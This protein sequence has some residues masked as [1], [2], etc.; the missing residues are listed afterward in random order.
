[1]TLK[2][3]TVKDD[4]ESW[5]NVAPI[6]FKAVSA[7]HTNFQ[8]TKKWT[9]KMEATQKKANEAHMELEA[10]VD[11][12]DAALVETRD[13]LET[14]RKEIHS[15][16]EEQGAVLEETRGRVGQLLVNCGTVFKL[17]FEAL[18]T[19]CGET[20]QEGH[21]AVGEAENPVASTTK[22]PD[23]AE[24]RDDAFEASMNSFT[25]AVTRWNAFQSVDFQ[26]RIQWQAEFADMKETTQKTV[27]SMS[28]WQG[29]LAQTIQSVEEMG[30][31]LAGTSNVVEEL[32]A[33]QVRMEDVDEAI[34]ACVRDMQEWIDRAE[35]RVENVAERSNAH[36]AN[37]EQLIGQARKQTEDRV[38][39]SSAQVTRMVEKNMSTVNAYLNRMHVKGDDLRSDLNSLISKIPRLTESVKGL[40]S[41]IAKIDA[42]NLVQI[43]VLRASV[44][45]ISS[46][47]ESLKSHSE[48]RC[49][50]FSASL[51]NVQQGVESQLAEMKACISNTS[52]ELT[53]LRSEE[54]SRVARNLISLEH[55]VAKWV[56]AM[57]LP[58]K[59]SEA[60]L[61]S[62]ESRLAQE[63]DARMNIECQLQIQ[64]EHLEPPR[65]SLSGRVLPPVE[66]IY[67]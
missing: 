13:G 43:E 48:D 33:T 57:P 49:S 58:A 9:E 12:G 64:P 23:A 52:L 63:T 14:L 10:R 30:T 18:L 21:F 6:V 15:S 54:V 8:N 60:R 56:H 19:G 22:V 37:A 53:T 59:V 11:A 29:K 50:D 28:E 46:T 5:E 55:K 32:R 38:D 4:K 41:E 35:R 42:T 27:E 26:R 31:N 44:S 17:I 16:I 61:F 66:M 1:M 7:C 62:L 67:R 40:N 34:N 65:M 47:L 39:E 25:S 20:V 45:D 24:A 51:N 2:V 36:A 3:L